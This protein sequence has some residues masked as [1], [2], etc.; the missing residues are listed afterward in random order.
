M[1]NSVNSY[2]LHAAMESYSKSGLG[3][4]EITPIY[5]V[6]GYEDTFIKFLSPEW[7]NN[8]NY[9][10]QEGKRLDLGVDLAMASG[11]PFG[12][13]WVTP[14]DACKY[15]VVKSYLLKEGEQLQ[16]IVV[17]IQTP[18]LRT[19][20]LNNLTMEQLKFPI[21][22]N[23]DSLQNWVID[24]V[25]F[26]KAMPLQVLIAYSDKGEIINL[27][28]NVDS[29]GK[30][31]WTAPAAIWK[32]YAVFEGCN[33]KMVERAGPGGEGDVIDQFSAKSMDRLL[34]NWHIVRN[35]F[36]CIRRQ[37]LASA[38]D[39]D[40]CN[41]L[42]CRYSFGAVLDRAIITWIRNCCIK[43]TKSFAGKTS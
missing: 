7:M 18:L 40:S 2:D 5:G 28:S 31:H 33:G 16:E 3:G 17:M 6:H 21:S 13:P 22:L 15:I 11:W 19:V 38:S 37:Q 32:L 30:L 35:R 12:G 8:L 10:L 23:E 36:R 20:R 34:P 27:T 25:R 42:R 14:D 39:A 43:V 1:C 41:H 4:L 29:D 26:P 24:Q 9:T